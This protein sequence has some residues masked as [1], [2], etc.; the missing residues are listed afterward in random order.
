[1]ATRYDREYIARFFDDY[2]EREWERLE[3]TPWGRVE[4]EV[5]RR[6]LR[7]FVR[8]GDR[9]L[10]VGAGPGRYTLELAD[11]GARVVASDVSPRQLELHRERTQAVEQA[12]EARVVADVLDLSAFEDGEFDAAVCIGGPLSYVLERVDDAVRELLRVTRPGGHVLGTV[13]SLLGGARAFGR[14]FPALIERFGWQRAVADVFETG[15]LEGEV[16]NGHVLR[17]YRWAEFRALL[18]R[19]P[20]RLVAATA[21][22]FLSAGNEQFVPDERWL[23][24]EVALCREPGA[25]DAGTHITAVVERV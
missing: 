14:H 4:L 17:L 5:H 2:G 24:I 15:L 23:D 10:E 13:M 11:I 25:L 7:E 19:H 8:P 16:N 18:E 1:M 9:V 12:V 6:L 20:C 3:A 22:N 21:T